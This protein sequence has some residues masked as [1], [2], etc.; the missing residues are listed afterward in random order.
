MSRGTPEIRYAE[1]ERETKYTRIQVVLD[2]DGGSRRDIATG[3]GFLDRMLS[4]FAVHGE[5]NIG[6][7]VDGDLLFD[8]HYTIEDVGIAI[9]MAISEALQES[10]PVLRTASNITP[11]G[12]ALVL[13]A[14]EINGRG[15][16]HFEIPFRRDTIGEVATENIAELFR[17]ICERGGITGHFRLMA[18][19]NDHHICEAVF[20]GFGKSLYEATRR[21][22]QPN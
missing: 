5:L 19:S 16:A 21:R 4:L 12:D 2:L 22:E 11:T 18:G 1:V 20:K 8:D 14:I 6:V 10:E 13:T 15:Q 9:G 7:K 3:L 17:A